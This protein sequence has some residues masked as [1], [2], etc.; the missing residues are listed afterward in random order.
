MEARGT[1]QAGIITKAVSKGSS[2][3]ADKEVRPAN[4]MRKLLGEPA[5]RKVFDNA[6][7]ENAG[8]FVS[9]LIDLFSSDSY[10][11]TCDPQAVVME[12]LKAATL[13]LPINK[14]LGF[15]Y[16]VP[17]KDGR[18]G[19]A[20]TP[21]FQLGY[22]GMIQLCL[23]S[24]AYKHINADVLYNGERVAVNRL[25]GT[26]DISGEKIS[27]NVVGYFAYFKLLNGFEKS[28][29]WSRESVVEHA[30]RFS[31]SYGSGSS[32]WTSDFD[33]MA[34]KTVLR[35]LLGH[36]GIMSTDF[37]AALESETDVEQNM[38]QALT[39]GNAD[40]ADK[41]ERKVIAA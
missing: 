10:L 4:A 36:Y 7:N 8:A 32:A 9:S 17:Y 3:E 23:R 24:N 28:V 39:S 13:H 19:G 5:I 14:Q 34:V 12:A 22:K 16:I 1:N 29:Y 33:A 6:L 20:M 31:K 41:E 2:A 26:V 38:A 21:H 35:D 15:A 40:G 27:D 25:S 18:N 11:Q 30:K 37:V